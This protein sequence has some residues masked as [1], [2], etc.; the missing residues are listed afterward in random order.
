MKT[1]F[2][3]PWA[4]EFGYEVAFWMGECEKIRSLYPDYKSIVSSFYGRKILYQSFNLFL[5]HNISSNYTSL[6]CMFDGEN[7][8]EH[9][10]VS[11]YLKNADIIIRPKSSFNGIVLGG[12]ND[13]AITFQ[14]HKKIIPSANYISLA[15]TLTKNK[16]VISIF[17]R[18][19]ADIPDPKKNAWE[20]SQWLSLIEALIKNNFF[21]VSLLAYYPQKKCFL[22]NLQTE[23]FLNIGTSFKDNED[24]CEIQAAFLNISQLAITT[25]CGGAQLILKTETP[26]IY[27]LAEQ[28]NDYHLLFKKL[29][30]KSNTPIK[31]LFGNGHSMNIKIEECLKTVESFFQNRD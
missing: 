30:E 10:E 24:F 28:N 22:E 17:C 4:G 9:P 23:N 11:T 15:R 12:G 26:C 29:N 21:V 1:I 20:E 16:K 5:P 31:Y 3:G 6:S 2:F 13:L 8:I 19:A 18:T 25:P 27:M 7:I 14:K